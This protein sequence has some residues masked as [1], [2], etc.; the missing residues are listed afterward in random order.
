MQGKMND[1]QYIN[2]REIFMR[3]LNDIKNNNPM[4]VPEGIADLQREKNVYILGT[5]YLKQALDLLDSYCI[6]YDGIVKGPVD[7]VEE[8]CV[9]YDCMDYEHVICKKDLVVVIAF[10][11]SRNAEYLR[12]VCEFENVRAVYILEGAEYSFSLVHLPE[13]HLFKHPK[14][15]FVDSYFKGVLKRQ[16]TYDYFAAH[17]DDFEQTYQWLSD[18]LSRETMVCY[19]DGHI[20]VKTFPMEPVRDASLQYYASG[21][22]NL[23]E[24]E[25]YVD[26]GEWDGDM[27]NRFLEQVNYKYKKIYVFEPDTQMIPKL[28]NNIDSSVD[29]VLID[30]GAYNVN[31]NMAFD[32]DGCGM[33][34]DTADGQTIKVTKIDDE[35]SEKISF[36]KMDIEGA[37]I[38][39]LEG[40]RKL[41]IRSLPKMAVCVYHK[42][43]DLITIPNVI[44]SLSR[45]YQL[46]L[47]AYH[48]YVQEV[49]LYAIPR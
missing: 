11:W 38:P 15:H 12:Q 9:N 30:K 32:N 46:Y 28:K 13:R 5:D 40:A 23:S 34:K 33:I 6:T 17:K 3:T 22:V 7:N 2:R 21:I 43:D 29:F 10:L 19:L 27:V 16:L 42:R 31:G 20:N 39:A 47:R 26:C 36:L 41:L 48:D 44:K 35:I 24:H 1:R 18:D 37:E 4:R 14:L 45:D 25:V 8:S 49:V